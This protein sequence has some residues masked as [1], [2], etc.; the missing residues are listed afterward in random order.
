MEQVSD[1][2]LELDINNNYSENYLDDCP[3]YSCWDAERF[4][5]EI[6]EDI[7]PK[8]FEWL[9]IFLYIFVFL[10]GVIGN[11]MVCYV[12]W[13][14]KMLKSVTNFFL[15]NLAVSDVMVITICLPATLV[16]DIL[17]TWFLDLLMCKFVSYMQVS[18][19]TYYD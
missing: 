6:N 14:N 18:P 4:R 8:F 16:H 9:L 15:V 3:D 7:Y 17:E 10:V 12:V 5:S 19:S 1:I 2:E 13:R 11:I